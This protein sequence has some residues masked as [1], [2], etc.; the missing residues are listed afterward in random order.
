MGKGGYK[1]RWPQNRN[2]YIAIGAHTSHVCTHPWHGFDLSLTTT[3]ARVH[4]LLKP[5]VKTKMF[6]L[7]WKSPDRYSS[8][9]ACPLSITHIELQQYRT[10]LNSHIP[11]AALP[12][13]ICK[14]CSLLMEK[15]FLTS[16]RHLLPFF[17]QPSF[18]ILPHP[19]VFLMMKAQIDAFVKIFKG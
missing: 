19:E 12:L 3:V 16:T 13:S 5:W 8:L 2:Y 10:N 1:S 17:L 18:E 7:T 4:C 11:N 6:G 9:M 14:R 15:G